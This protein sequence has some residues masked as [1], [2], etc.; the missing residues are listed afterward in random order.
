ME[1]AVMRA[2][3]D[4]YVTKFTADLGPEGRKAVEAM[5][6]MAREKNI[7]PTFPSAVFINE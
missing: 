7:I 2:H 6:E 4:L 1:D 5:F 3:I